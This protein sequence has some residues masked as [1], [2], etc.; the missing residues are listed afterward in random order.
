MKNRGFTVVELLVGIVV[1]IITLLAISSLFFT[2]NRVIQIV[3]PASESIEEV[4]T[5]L[6]TLDFLMSRWG[7]GFP[8]SNNCVYDATQSCSTTFNSFNASSTNLNPYGNNP[9][10]INILNNGSEVQFFASL[11]GSGFVKSSNNNSSQLI[12]CRLSSQSKDNCYFLFNPAFSGFARLSDLSANNRDCIDLDITSQTNAT[13]TIDLNTLPAGSS[14]AGS[15]LAGG[16]LIRAP[17]FVRIY[18]QDGWLRMDKKDISDCD[19][20]ENAVNI[21]KV[22][23]FTAQSLSSGSV[24]FTIEFVSQTDPNK[25]FRVERVYTR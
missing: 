15:S 11:G 22:R 18:I 21:A 4:Q 16:L 5:G 8:C 10:C 24:K 1:S 13:A 14:L 9:L 19:D 12:S 25:V 2:S 20:N 17:H 23:S 6:A 3:K 7:V